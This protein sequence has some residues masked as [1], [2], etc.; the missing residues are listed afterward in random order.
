MYQYEII[1][2]SAVMFYIQFSFYRKGVDRLPLLEAAKVLSD[3]G[4]VYDD[5]AKPGENLKEYIVNGALGDYVS[6]KNGQWIVLR[7]EIDWCDE[8]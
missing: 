6:V 1:N 3:E 5:P 8:D 4:P 2:I 7:S